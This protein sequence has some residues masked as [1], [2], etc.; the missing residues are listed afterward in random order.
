VE[1]DAS[2]NGA[3]IEVT[4]L[5]VAPVADDDGYCTDE[6]VTLN[7]PAPGVLAGDSDANGDPLLAVLEGDPA[8]GELALRADGSFVYTPTAN[9]HGA[10]NFYYRASDGVH[11]SNPATVTLTVLEE[12]LHYV[13]L[14]LS[15]RSMAAPDLV[16]LSL[17]ATPGVIQ[18]VIGNQGTAPAVPDFWVDVYIAPDPVPERVNQ[19]WLHVA[20]MGLVWDVWDTLSPGQTLTLTSASYAGPYSFIVWPLAAGTPVYAQVDTWNGAT[21]YG[22]VREDHEILGQPYNNIEHTTVSATP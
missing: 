11:H 7:V 14:P 5:N 8:H 6:A 10:D 16:V 15:L 21:D 13:Y 12:P 19:T 17:S 1:A 2:S 20:D 4:V 9:Y 18:V 3:A 22:A